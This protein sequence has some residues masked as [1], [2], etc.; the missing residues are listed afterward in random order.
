MGKK[1][2]S[3]FSKAKR[4]AYNSD[5]KRLIDSLWDIADRVQRGLLSEARAMERMRLLLPRYGFPP[6]DVDMAYTQATS[7]KMLYAPHTMEQTAQWDGVNKP[8]DF[9]KS[10]G[11]EGLGSY[12]ARLKQGKVKAKPVQL[13]DALFGGAYQVS[14]N[15]LGKAVGFGLPSAKKVKPIKLNM[16][17]I[18][19]GVK[20]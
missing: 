10:I 17:T 4:T 6:S 2:D 18:L 3:F 1:L 13:G 11:L 20:K 19:W 8:M 7:L 14:G 9:D 12:Q 16:G 15:F 5:A